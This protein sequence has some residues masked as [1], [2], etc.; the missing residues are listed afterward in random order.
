MHFID[1]QLTILTVLA[2]GAGMLLHSH[3]AFVLYHLLRVA[4]L[5]RR[6]H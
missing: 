3:S 6:F 1:R 5:V 2:I 4:E